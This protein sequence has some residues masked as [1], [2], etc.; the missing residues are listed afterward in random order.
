MVILTCKLKGKNMKKLLLTA[1]TLCLLSMGAEAQYYGDSYSQ[2]RNSQYGGGYSRQQGQSYQ[3]QRSSQQRA[4]RTGTNQRGQRQKKKT[5]YVTP[6]LGY[7]GTFGWDDS[8]VDT[9]WSPILGVA[10]GMYFNQF[11]IEGEVDYHMKKEL[12]SEKF[13]GGSI[14]ADYSQLDFDINGYYDFGK[15]NIR[16]FV[17][18]GIGLSKLKI[19]AKATGTWGGSAHDSWSKTKL[20]LAAMAGCTFNIT[21]MMAFEL[22]G[23]ARYLT[24]KGVDYNLE[25]IAGLRFSF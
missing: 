3:R 12:Y 16:P 8:D 2:S 23:R 13:Y 20:S 17:G 22:M 11:R 19:D 6:R 5:F 15:G 18:A 21:D 10:A 7:G 25:G 24:Q 14:K 1:T 9:P 4:Y